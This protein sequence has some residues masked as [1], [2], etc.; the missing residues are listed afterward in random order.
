[1][2]ET[3][4][5]T[6]DSA[7]HFFGYYGINPWDEPGRY[8]LALR[9][10]FHRRPPLSNDTAEV[11]IVD[12]KTGS[13][14]GVAKTK[15]FN[16]QQG[17]MLHWIKKDS[18]EQLTF[19][20]WQENETVTHTYSLSHDSTTVLE[21]AIAA[22]SPSKLQAIGLNY[23]RMYH[24]RSV[25]GYTNHRSSR[26][27]ISSPDDDGLFAI[28]LNTGKADLIVSLAQVANI[29]LPK[30][31]SDHLVWFNHVMFNTDGSRLLFFCRVLRTDGQRF[32]DSLWTVCPDGSELSLEIS[33]KHKVSH[34][35]WM[36]NHKILASTDI[37]GSM[38]FV[39]FSVN[40]HN[41]RPFGRGVLPTDGHPSFSPDH[42]WL[43]C[44]TY[45]SKLNRESTVLLYEIDSGKRIDIGKFFSESIFSGDIRCDLHPRWH[46]F[47]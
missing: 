20:T 35:A 23:A 44:D 46:N 7:N 9:T 21:K 16:F 27:L 19:N 37:L 28:N 18:D 41:F 6:K 14:R 8:H 12:R 31:Y 40:Q 34:Y 39:T 11:G 5:L 13:F 17:S 25:V 38:Q 36:N 45:P 10:Y 15:A 26:K 43:V 24:C 42:R 33:F 32:L 1:M 3:Q 29:S 4:Q 47:N 22:V 2:Y 30:I